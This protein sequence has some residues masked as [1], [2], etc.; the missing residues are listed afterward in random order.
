MR[1][2]N[3]RSQAL[4]LLFAAGA[5]EKYEVVIPMKTRFVPVIVLSMW[6][7][8]LLSRPLRIPIR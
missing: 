1:F 7:Y 4:I 5:A 2:A 6:M 3:Y 8:A